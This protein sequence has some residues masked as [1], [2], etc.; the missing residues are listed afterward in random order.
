MAWWALI[1]PFDLMH[2]LLP[3]K[4]LQGTPISYR[5]RGFL[6]G[7][8]NSDIF[9]NPKTLEN[10]RFHKAQEN[11]AKRKIMIFFF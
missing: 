8:H 1:S 11:A 10:R 3:V 5:F 2:F 6:Y 4:R 7:L 9:Q